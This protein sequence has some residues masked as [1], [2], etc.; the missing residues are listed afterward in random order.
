MS[1]EIHVRFW[2]SPGVR[3]PRAT[4][5]T[6]GFQHRGE[7]ERFLR[8]LHGRL[9]KF[10]LELHPEKTRLI[11][12]GRFA[13]SNRKRRGEGKPETFDFL[14]FTHCCAKTR[15]GRF[16]IRRRSVAKRLRATLQ[17]VK[18]EL[19]RRM[20]SPLVQQGQ[21][22]RSVVRGWF[23]YHAVPLNGEALS[24]FRT[25]VVRMWRHALRRRSQKGRRKWN[26]GRMKR[27]VQ[28]WIP[29]TRILHPYPEQRLIATHPK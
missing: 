23:Q 17:A 10:G 13:A 16:V 2:E 8:E 25:Q 5:L 9:E 11:E 29:P 12:F 1:R 21:W 15:H 4:R 28:R 27:L 24:T 18:A 14:G 22:L 19:T 20:H 6:I 7:A 3:L 26:W